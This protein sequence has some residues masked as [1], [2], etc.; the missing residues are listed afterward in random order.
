MTHFRSTP[1]LG[2]RAAALASAAALAGVLGVPACSS[3]TPPSLGLTGGSS[4]MAGSGA[5][6]GSSATIA[7]GGRA[8]GSGSGAS[9]G[10]A[11]G[12]GGTTSVVV[13]EAGAAGASESSEAGAAGVA[14]L[15]PDQACAQS[16]TTVE[17]VPSILELVVDTSGSMDWPPGWEPVD[18]NDSKP[19][20]ATKWEITRDALETAVDAL[21]AGTALGANFFPATTDDDPDSMCLRK[22]VALPIAALGPA[23]S[24]QRSDW[25]DALDAVDP[26]GGTPTEGAY[27]YGLEL[28]GKTKLNGNQFVLLITD[29]TPTCTL[30]CRCND[31]NVAVDSEPLIADAKQALA[32][33]VR[34]FVIGSPGSEQT[35]SVLSAIA[36][37]GGTGTPGCSDDGPDYCHLDMTTEPDLAKGLAGALAQVAASLR[38]CEYPLPPAPDDRTLD[39]GLVNVLY[40]PSG[41]KPRTIARDPSKS[42][43]NEG[44]QYT[45]DG[46]NITLCGDACAAA[47]ADA[48]SQ[49]QVLLGCKTVVVE[50]R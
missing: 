30:N 6:A 42:D 48:G 22:E 39:P 18:P 26:Y 33:G 29:G 45:P 43:C 23:G 7:V 47:R 40:T 14:N 4:G 50:P 24:T 49:V 35:R 38:S 2:F 8:G 1:V 11:T 13:T 16:S 44:W 34:T 25:S 9:G 41:G 36:R 19:P 27:L 17:A 5:T 10:R 31:G 3:S 15:D 46:K 28:L 37:E 21:D 20:G 32:G 12:A